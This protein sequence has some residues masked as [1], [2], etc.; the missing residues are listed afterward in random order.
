MSQKR[1]KRGNPTFAGEKSAILSCA[2]IVTLVL[3]LGMLADPQSGQIRDQRAAWL[4]MA[5]L[6]VAIAAVIY[7]EY[8]SR[9]RHR[10]PGR[11]ERPHQNH[12][13]CRGTETAAARR[14]PLLYNKQR[15]QRS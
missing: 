11:R 7:V 6:P 4:G 1:R 9:N 14:E 2:L 13:V 8:R 5:A 3:F 15:N 10:L 12:D